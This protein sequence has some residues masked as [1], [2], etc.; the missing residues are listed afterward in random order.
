MRVPRISNKEKNE[1]TEARTSTF[2]QPNYSNIYK[3]TNLKY[4][5]KLKDLTAHTLYV[6][7]KSFR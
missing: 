1:R 2:I 3:T 4:V 7:A 5:Q 6:V